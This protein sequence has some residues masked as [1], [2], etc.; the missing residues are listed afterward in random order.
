MRS[1]V[2]KLV[3]AAG[4]NGL[5]A[6]LVFTGKAD[7]APLITAIGTQLTALLGYHAVTNL[8]ATPKQ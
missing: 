4:L 7:A 6:A 1:D 8:Q 3:A 2:L 5:W